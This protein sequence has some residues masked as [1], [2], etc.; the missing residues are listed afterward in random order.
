MDVSTLPRRRRRHSYDR[1]ASYEALVDAALRQFHAHGYAATRIEDIV[2]AAG[3]TRGAFYF[4][5]RNTRQCFWAVVEHRER[6]RGDWVTA[7]TA[8]LGAET[9]L[10]AVLARTFA[11]FAAAERGLGAWI[12]V[13]VDFHQ[14][15]RDDARAHGRLARIYAEWHANLIRFVEALQSAGLARVDKAADVL[16]REAFAFVEGLTA[17]ARLYG[18]PEATLDGTLLDGL[19][20][21]LGDSSA[22]A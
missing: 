13:M 21:L 2:Q 8:E 4:H 11:R 15:H 6:R 1:D 22:R 19:V 18:L 10:A 7:V 17:H 5:F 12:L 20:A 14:Q 9:T 16:A 3:Y